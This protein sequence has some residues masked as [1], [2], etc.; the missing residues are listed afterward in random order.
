MD[1]RFAN[2]YSVKRQFEGILSYGRGAYKKEVMG[3]INLISVGDK[4][5]KNTTMLFCCQHRMS[6]ELR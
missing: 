1:C 6:L 4:N 3:Q 2:I 5:N